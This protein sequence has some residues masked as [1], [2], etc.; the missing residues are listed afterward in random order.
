[1][2]DDTFSKKLVHSY[3]ARDTHLDCLQKQKV[4]IHYTREGGAAAE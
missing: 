2:K 4:N 1:M 3:S